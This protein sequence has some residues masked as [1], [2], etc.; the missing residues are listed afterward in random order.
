[1]LYY[2]SE[3]WAVQARKAVTD[4]KI[5]RLRQSRFE[6]LPAEKREVRTQFGALCFRMRS[7]APQILLITSRETHRW[8]LPKGWPMPGMSP[9]EAAQRE[10]WEEAGAKGRISSQCLGI[11]SYFKVMD[12]GGLPCVVALFPMKV[13][14]LA[15]DFPERDE[16]RRKWFPAKK[17]AT[18]VDEP[19]LSEILGEFD[20]T[21]FFG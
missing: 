12:R 9:V 18:K 6:D 11:Y 16:R 21:A 17:A 10:A 2:D 4:L 20:P 14:R 13:T 15:K 8:V 3:R 7:G 5:E 19:E 1:M